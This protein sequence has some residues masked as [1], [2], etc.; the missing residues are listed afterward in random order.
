VTERARWTTGSR[1]N[2]LLRLVEDFG[3]NYAAADFVLTADDRLV[4]LEI[5]AGGEWLWLCSHHGLPIDL[6]LAE[7]LAGEAERTVSW[8]WVRASQSTSLSS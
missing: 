2:C 4:F 3:L 7:V 1:S 8:P 6:A 5:N